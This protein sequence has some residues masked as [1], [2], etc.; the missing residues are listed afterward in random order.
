[1]SMREEAS[2]ITKRA[3]QQKK[4]E[5][6]S[7]PDA[8]KARTNSGLP[9]PVPQISIAGPTAGDS[10]PEP[11]DAAIMAEVP[12]RITD[13]PEPLDPQQ[14]RI[15]RRKSVSIPIG[16]EGGPG[17]TWAMDGERPPPSSLAGRKDTLEARKLAKVLDEHYSRFTAFSIWSNVSIS[18]C[19]EKS[20]FTDLRTASQLHDVVNRTPLV[21]HDHTE[22]RQDSAASSS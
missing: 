12:P 5:S 15:A 10:T 9:S 11:P 22:S 18:L 16:L 19:C 20:T 2:R 14:A 7:A 6:Q 1:M 21:R 8:G 4:Q 13:S 17:G 3:E